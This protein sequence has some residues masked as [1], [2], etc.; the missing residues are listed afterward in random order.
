MQCWQGLVCWV[1]SVCS[2]HTLVG[3]H[4]LSLAAPGSELSGE[5]FIMG[6]E[7]KV[8]TGQVVQNGGNYHV[9]F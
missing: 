1:C 3:L 8:P 6:S 4:S 2:I 5:E 7:E 9:S